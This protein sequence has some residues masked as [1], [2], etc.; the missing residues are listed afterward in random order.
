LASTIPE[1]LYMLVPVAVL[2]GAGYVAYQQTTEINLETDA[3]AALGAT[4]VTGYL[5]FAFLGT[6]LVEYSPSSPG[7]A[8]ASIGPELGTAV[9]IAGLFYPLVFGA[10]GAVVAKKR[11]GGGQRMTQHPNNRY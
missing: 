9:M 3:V 10:I 8:S 1:I 6:F 5:A 2:A 11:N 4:V 7:A